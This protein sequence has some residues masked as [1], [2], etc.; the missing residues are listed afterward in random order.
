MRLEVRKFRGQ[1]PTIIGISESAEESKLLDLLNPKAPGEMILD[2][3][4]AKGTFE[5]RLSDGYGEHYIRLK[6]DGAPDD[7]G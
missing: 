3:V 7:V 4:F 1:A 5:V 6:P 2:D